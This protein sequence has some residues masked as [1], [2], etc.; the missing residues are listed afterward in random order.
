MGTWWRGT[1]LVAERGIVESIRSRTFKVV[2]GILLVLSVA[3]VVV[4][5]M[6]R[7][8]QTTYTLATAGPT[9][10]GLVAA[11]DAAGRAADF[12]VRYETKADVT[13]VR[14]AVRDGDATAGLVGD[15]LYTSMASGTFPIVVAQSV[16]ALETSRRLMEA[17]LTP[18]QIAGIQSVRPP[19]QVDVGR[20]EDARSV[21]GFAVGI[22]LFLALTFAGN[23]IATT[24]AMEKSTRISEVLLA[25]LRP[26]QALVGTVAA[27]GAVTFL[28]LIVLVTPLAVA[29]QVMNDVELP[30]V[31]GG[32]LAIAVVWFVLGFALY[33]FLFA[34]A[35]SL[36]DKITEVGSATMPVTLVLT[37]SYLVAITVVA[38]NPEGVW[39]VAASLFPLTA[40][41]A[42]PVRWAGGLVP[43]WQLLLAMALTVGAAVLLVWMASAIYRRAL[44]ITGR[45]VKVTEV[46][47][48]G[49]RA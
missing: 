43:V 12:T 26:S 28:Q 37:G 17:G 49:R 35:A 39:G 23:T 19:Q 48:S 11:L 34:A 18:A 46:F 40:P 20:V 21:V 5:Q 1:A 41:I 6:L 29:V 25:V 31:A 36:V 47:R 22:V 3:A 14:Q 10:T 32:D 38:A 44:V 4:P 8:D 30:P 9:P 24:V 42:M 13:A 16:V 27:V 45:R 15:S 2:T 33:A 7:S